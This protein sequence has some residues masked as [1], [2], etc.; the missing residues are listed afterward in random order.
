MRTDGELKRDMEE[1]LKYD[2]DM[3]STNIGVSVRQGVVSMTGSVGS[4]GQKLQAEAAAKRVNGV[5]DVANGIQVRL[6]AAD[7]RPDAEIARELT[8]QFEVVLP[9]SFGNVK[10]V[11]NNGWVTLEGKLEWNYHRTLAESTALR[12]KGVLEVIN[13]IALA[14]H[15]IPTEVKATI[16]NALKR[17]AQVD[18]NRIIVDTHGGQVVLRGNVRSWAERDEV[19]RVAWLAPGVAKVANHITLSY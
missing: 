6:A 11:V 7:S 9:F 2:P 8:A 10:S 5:M 16:E 18:G 13:R 15:M 17:S 14:P 3:D 1:E 19:E 12:V 4:Y